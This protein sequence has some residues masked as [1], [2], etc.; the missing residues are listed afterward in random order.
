M[1]K[2]EV[3]AVSVL[4]YVKKLA[5][6]YSSPDLFRVANIIPAYRRLASGA[7]GMDYCLYGGP[8]YGRILVFSGKEHSG[9]TT[10]AFALLAA[11]QRENPDKVCLF[12]DAE[13][14][15]D[16][17]FQALMNGVDL[18][19]LIVFT[20]DE[21]MS[22]EQILGAV[23]EIQ[24]NTADIGLIVIDSIPALETAQNLNHEFEKDMGKQGTIAK[25]LA[26]FCKQILPSLRKKQNILILINQVRIKDVMY[27]GAPIY[28]EPGG[29]GPK[30]YGSTNVRFGTR[31]FMRKDVEGNSNDG[32]GA[33][34]FR[35]KFNITKNKTAACN[36]GGGFITYRYETGMDKMFDLLEIATKFDYIQRVN[37]VTYQLINLETGELLQDENGKDLKGKKKE[38]VEYINTHPDFR[39]TYFTMLTDYISAANTQKKAINLLDQADLDEINQEESAMEALVKKAAKQAKAEEA[40]E[41][42]EKVLQEIEEENAMMREREGA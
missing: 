42:D 33:D 36:R 4:D 22:G 16:L 38:L 17:Q 35:I 25:S 20:P 34:G 24:L 7:L 23:L 11:F 37:N 9:K 27:N 21:G 13:Q 40:E 30:F 15:L 6:E 41:L 26:K 10:G 32:E 29:S 12:V 5:K 1:A 28:D 18:N 39:E 19:R 31:T 8:A 2:E 14:S 3:K